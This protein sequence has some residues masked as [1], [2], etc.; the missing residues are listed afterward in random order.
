[1]NRS[2]K[3][4]IIYLINF[5]FFS[6]YSISEIN[7]DLKSKGCIKLCYN[8]WMKCPRCLQD[9]MNEEGYCKHCDTP[10]IAAAHTDS[11][12]TMELPDQKSIEIT[13]GKDFG[14]RYKILDVI[15]K[16]GMGCVYKALDKDLELIVALKLIRAELSTNASILERFK[17]ELLLARSISHE[18]VIR[19]HDLGDVGGIKY[20]SM[21]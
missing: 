15:G 13:S 9:S 1:M 16:G 21:A 2:T 14:S 17:R 3:V 7:K 18:N 6:D 12:P 19:I 5:I 20:L 11:L 8:S 10:T 4:K